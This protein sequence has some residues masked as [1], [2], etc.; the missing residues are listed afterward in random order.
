ML[1]LLT[2]DGVNQFPLAHRLVGLNA[3]RLAGIAQLLLV[4]IGHIVARMLLNQLAH[5]GTAVRRLEINLIA[6]HLHLRGAVQRQGDT[7][8]HG[9]HKL[10]HPVV[11]LIGHINL[12][13]GELGVVGPVHTLVAEIAAE[14]IHTFIPAD[15]KPFQIQ[16]IGYAQ[17]QVDVQSIVVRDKGTCSGSAGDDLQH[18]CVHLQ[19]A[20]LVE[21][22]A[23]CV[24]NLCP[25]HKSLPHVRIHNQIHITHTV[26]LLGVA[27]SIVHHAV[28]L[29]HNGQRTEALAKHRQALHMDGNLTHLCD[30]HIT[31]HTDNV[32][33]IQQTLEHRVVHRLVL[34]RANL[35]AF[36]IQLDSSMRVLQFHKRCRTHNSAAH[37]ATC[38]TDVLK[39][40]VILRILLQNLARFGVHLIQCG[41]IGVNTQ[42]L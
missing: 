29:L 23:H 11:V 16:F 32:A 7:L 28:L 36:H 33:D 40:R 13:T 37:D 4:H 27:E 14:L 22:L 30:E 42:F 10:H 8:Q 38:Y 3:Q 25:L 15:D 39:Q 5:R 21:V 24:H 17:I 34:A 19:I 9:L 41:G 31:L 35:V 18:R 1:A 20:L 2:E 26:A 6:P 12:H